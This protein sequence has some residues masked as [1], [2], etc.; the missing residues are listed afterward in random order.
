[1]E[2]IRSFFQQEEALSTKPKPLAEAASE[3]VERP[4]TTKET[5]KIVERPLPVERQ[6][7]PFT[8]EQLREALMKKEEKREERKEEPSRQP[9]TIERDIGSEIVEFEHALH[10]MHRVTLPTAQPTSPP[11]I[12]TSSPTN[13]IRTPERA[14]MHDGFFGEF[15][16]FLAREELEAD[17]IFEKD[18][19]AKM[20]EFH[21]RRQEG[22]EYYLYSK[23]MQ[24]AI[25]RKLA[26]LK[27]LE[28]DWFTLR[29]QCDEIERHIVTIEHEIEAST[30][31]L[32]ELMKQAKAKSRLEGV[33]PEGREF[34]LG[35]GRKL[36]SLLDLK[37]ALHTM[38]SEVFSHHVNA[39]K[40]DFAAWARYA[41]NDPDLAD[42]MM[43]LHDKTQLEIMLGKISGK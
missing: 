23:D 41:H 33:V 37:I 7:L 28:H 13:S 14:P 43:A 34:Q 29:G 35:D 25:N 20:R 17:G 27:S 40:N 5:T 8:P 4:P 2:N 18:I 30:G 38:R 24:Q 39:T 31:D 19:L 3:V 1:V 6:P 9:A 15:E 16:Q 26:E 12:V 22:K 32:K 10:D 11:P 42:Q 21:R 36:K